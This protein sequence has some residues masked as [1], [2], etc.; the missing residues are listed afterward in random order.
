M[1]SSLIALGANL[2]DRQRTLN[3]AIER[4][5]A[6]RS[7]ESLSQSRWHETAPIGGP[8]GQGPFLNAAVRLE[9]TAS[10]EQLHQALRTIEFDLGRRRVERWEARAIDLDL[11][12]YAERVIETPQLV[13]PH[14]R[15]AFRRF[16]LEAAVEVA[17]EMVHPSIGWTVGRLLDHLNSAV[18]YVSLLGLPGSNKTALAESLADAFHGR[19]LLHGL[20]PTPAEMADSTPRGT[21]DPPSQRFARQIQF[22]DR[23]TSLLERDSWSRTSPLAV[24]DFYLDQC[25]AFARI[26]LDQDQ[27]AAFVQAWQVA[28]QRA[29]SPKLLIALDTPPSALA[30]PAR[31]RSVH[32]ESDWPPTERLRHEMLRLACRKGLGP[33]LLVGGMDRQAQYEEISAAIT[34]MH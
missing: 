28:K 24:S 1:P 25:L 34:S 4:L 3:V 33:V 26:E 11:L 9:T 13:V 22:L 2:G 27:Q 14:P 8:A 32:A 17:S 20:P 10:A 6:L 31:Q 23:F 12:L 7:T 5:A 15:M 19:T 29:V 21:L 16:V 30:D 18:E